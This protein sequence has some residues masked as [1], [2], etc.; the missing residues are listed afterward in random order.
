[1]YDAAREA[2]RVL[3]VVADPVVRE[4]T[5]SAIENLSPSGRKGVNAVE[6][7]GRGVPDMESRVLAPE[8][9]VKVRQWL[10]A[11][12]QGRELGHSREPCGK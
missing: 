8:T 10:E 6:I 9:R 3:G 4:T 2:I 1:M 11:P 5:L 7:G 12:I